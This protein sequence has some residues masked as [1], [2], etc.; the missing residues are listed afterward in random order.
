MELSWEIKTFGEFNTEELYQ[1]L[2]L[3]SEIFVVEQTCV[4]QD[5]DQQDQQSIHVIG[6]D[7]DTIAAYA[8]IVPRKTGKDT[9][10][11]RVVIRESYRGKKLGDRL[12]EKCIEACTIHYKGLSLE[13]S[14]QKH[15]V[16][17]YSKHGFKKEG[18]PYLE[19]GIPHVL[20][21]KESI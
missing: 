11:G 1:I 20:M 12:I 2:A 18:D 19:D 17:Y 15:L 6:K 13:M 21:R 10:I 16:K 9:S 7:N 4:Y 8:R 3:R 14:A 5:I